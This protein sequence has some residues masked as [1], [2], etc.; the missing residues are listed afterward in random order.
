MKNEEYNIDEDIV[1]S[2]TEREVKVLELFCKNKATGVT[3]DELSKRLNIK[4]HSTSYYSNK[5]K[6]RKLI[7]KKADYRMVK[8]FLTKKGREACDSL[9][10]NV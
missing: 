3:S 4:I 6:E 9:S 8:Y 7:R 1:L 5:L 10:R 2:L